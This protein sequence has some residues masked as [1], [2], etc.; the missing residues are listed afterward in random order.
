MPREVAKLLHDIVMAGEATQDFLRDKSL[1][2]FVSDLL[3]RSAVER[4]LF[5]VGEAIAQLRQLEPEIAEQFPDWRSIISFRNLVALGYFAVDPERVWSI[6]TD[7][8]VNT[9][10]IANSLFQEQ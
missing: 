9:I 10:A 2:D 3:L 4:Q 6:A 8:V 5:I 1:S 7:E